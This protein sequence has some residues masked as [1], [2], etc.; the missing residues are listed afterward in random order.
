M[1]DADKPKF[2]ELLNAL[3]GAHN[4]TV[5]DGAVTGYWKGLEKMSLMQF[6]RCVGKA[7]E[8]LAHSER[9]V[10][11]IPTVS[12]LWDLHRGIRH[13]DQP[14]V[15]TEPQWQG[16]DWD[17]SANLL[18]VQKITNN[19][20]GNPNYIDYAPDSILTR[21]AKA[22]PGPDTKAIAEIL[23]KWKTVWARDMREDRERGGNLDGKPAWA[24]CM[25]Q[26][27]SE[28]RAYL[29]QRAA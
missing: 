15:E 6:E 4:R 27:D 13:Y 23:A 26:A 28:I 7:I 29:A 1:T 11:K 18:L 22:I 20:P 3:F 8:K 2:L 5:W 10:S 17:I 12:E 19:R 24:Y 21:E 14:K 25:A 16:D 9:G